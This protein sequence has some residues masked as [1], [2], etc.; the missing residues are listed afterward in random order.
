[1]Q[2][3]DNPFVTYVPDYA[4]LLPKHGL[5]S[6]TEEM[7]VTMFDAVLAIISF[8]AGRQHQLDLSKST[9]YAVGVMVVFLVG[10]TASDLVEFL[11][12]RSTHGGF[13]RPFVVQPV[14]KFAIIVASYTIGLVSSVITGFFTDKPTKGLFD[15][16]DLVMPCIVI[17]LFLAFL[18]EPQMRQTPRDPILQQFVDHSAHASRTDAV[19]KAIK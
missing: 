1:M 4:Q 6:M 11:R 15:F 12:Y 14:M 9:H 8:A 7:M 2:Q 5:P 16:G 18:M 13:K 17:L 19:N 3:G 10:M